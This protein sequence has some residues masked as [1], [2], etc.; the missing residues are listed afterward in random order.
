MV[1]DS[2]KNPLLNRNLLVTH[3]TTSS[4]A[5]KLANVFKKGMKRDPILFLVLK[6]DNQ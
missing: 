5:S 6:E 4:I 2:D 1:E 3:I